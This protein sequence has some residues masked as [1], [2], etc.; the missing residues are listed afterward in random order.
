MKWHAT[1]NMAKYKNRSDID[2]LKMHRFDLRIKENEFNQSYDLIKDFMETFYK[3]YP[4]EL[5]LHC[6]NEWKQALETP[7]KV[8]NLKFN[9][10]LQ[11]AEQFID[12]DT[13]ANLDKELF[14][15][16]AVKRKYPWQSK[17][18]NVETANHVFSL[19]MLELPK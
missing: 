12:L 1:I 14:L 3:G 16:L 8:Q 19:F 9:L 15:K 6:Q 17:I 4:I 2:F 5:A 10:D 7:G 13:L 11:K 18:I